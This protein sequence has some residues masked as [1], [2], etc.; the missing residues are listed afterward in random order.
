MSFLVQLR[1]RTRD[2]IFS[3]AFQRDLNLASVGETPCKDERQRTLLF[4][5]TGSGGMHV[6]MAQ[7]P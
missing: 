4:A 2:N 5:C 1:I 6:M 3:R 7:V